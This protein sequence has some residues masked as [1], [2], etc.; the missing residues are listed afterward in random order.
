MAID[1]KK[2]RDSLLKTW[3]QVF[4]DTPDVNWAVFGYDGKTNDLKVVETG[5][6]DLDEL[7]DELNEGKILYAGIKVM[8]PNTNLPKIVFINWQGEGVPSSRKGVCARHVRDVEAFFRGAHVTINAR[9]TDDVE[10]SVVV[11]KVKNASGANYSFHKEK[12]K[13]AEPIVPVGSV[14]QK[15]RVQKE[16]NVQERDKF[17]SKSEEDEKKR[18]EEERKQAVAAKSEAERKR[19]ER[20]AKE[21]EVREKQY[22]ERSRSIEEQ[23]RKQRETEEKKKEEERTRWEQQ[24]VQDEREMQQER[25]R[26]NSLR[27]ARL[28]EAESLIRQGQDQK[29][30][31]EEKTGPAPPPLKSKPPPRRPP[32]QVMPQQPEPEPEPEPEIEPEPEPVRVEPEPEPEPEPELEEEPTDLYENVETPKERQ[33]PDDTYDNLEQEIQDEPVQQQVEPTGEAAGYGDE[34]QLY[35]NAT[36][37]QS[38]QPIGDQGKCARALYDYQAETED[39][40]SFDPGDIISEIDELDEGWWRGRGPDGHYGMFPANYVEL[41]EGTEVTTSEVEPV[42]KEELSGLTARALYDYQAGDDSEI[43]FDPGDIITDIEQIDDGW[44]KGKGPDGQVGLFPA[45]Y[46]ELIA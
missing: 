42:H 1:L 22:R 10:E 4:D 39:E 33:P 37:M 14:Y 8:D 45:N 28:K 44:W 34:E 30:R 35:D 29:P 38:Q 21:A 25:Q 15:V 12:A 26:A 40:I 3:Q 6:G 32:P 27:Q 31:F 2:N 43:T 13:P 18:K 36:P 9:S 46:V 19:K 16:I 7:V 11:E 24:Q 20:E 5:D 17:W 41:I 23:K